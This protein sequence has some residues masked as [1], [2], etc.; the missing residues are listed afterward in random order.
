MILKTRLDNN[1]KNK[2]QKFQTESFLSIL[3]CR[4]ENVLEVGCGKG[5]FSYVGG[6]NQKFTNCFG[7]D[8]FDN[9][10]LEELKLV[11]HNVSYRHMDLCNSIP[12]E[13]DSFDLVFSMDVIEH[14]DDDKQFILEKIRVCKPGGLIIIGTPNYYRIMNI[15]LKIVNRLHYPRKVGDDTYGDVIHLRAYKKSELKSLLGGFQEEIE[16]G[17]LKI[18]PVWYGIMP[19]NLGLNNMPYLFQNICQFWLASFCKRNK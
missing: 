13:S 18:M 17:T 7:C 1:N 6:L 12:Y 10:Q 16:V 9:Y 11:C 4:Y 19:L 14:I 5:Y 15:F 3:N 2:F 8:I